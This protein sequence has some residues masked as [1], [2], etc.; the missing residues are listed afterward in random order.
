[1]LASVKYLW[2]CY[3][4]IYH[5]LAT[6]TSLYGIGFKYS[7]TM[8]LLI[9]HCVLVLGKAKKLPAI[10]NGFILKMGMWNYII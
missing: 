3:V 7:Y 4:A 8:S 1:M 10:D 5:V 9:K 2:Q 6:P